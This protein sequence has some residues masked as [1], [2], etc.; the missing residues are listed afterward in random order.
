MARNFLPAN[1]CRTILAPMAATA[2]APCSTIV[3]ASLA[4]AKAAP[5]AQARRA[6]MSTSSRRLPSRSAPKGKGSFCPTRNAAAGIVQPGIR[7][8]CSARAAAAEGNKRQS[9]CSAQTDGSRE[10]IGQGA[11][12]ERADEDSSRIRLG[13]QRRAAP[14]RHRPE[15]RRVAA[16]NCQ[17]A[18]RWLRAGRCVRRVRQRAGHCGSGAGGYG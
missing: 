18:I 10:K 13:A 9:G 1:G 6:R 3:P 17:R 16:T 4:T 7:R 8:H 2:W 12:K 15:V 14:F 11:G 5:A